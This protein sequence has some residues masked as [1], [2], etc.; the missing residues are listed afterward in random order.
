MNHGY[1]KQKATQ[2]ITSAKST[3]KNLKKSY[4]KRRERRAEEKREITLGQLGL[5]SY[6][7]P[8]IAREYYRLQEDNMKLEE[9]NHRLESRV[10][11]I[12][13]QHATYQVCPTVRGARF[14]GYLLPE[15]YQTENHEELGIAFAEYIENEVKHTTLPEGS[16]Y[17][18]AKNE[19][20]WTSLPEKLYWRRMRQYQ[21]MEEAK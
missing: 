1:A 9:A 12:E 18:Y 4:I 17:S 3:F 14:K 20:I 7:L 2:I 10:K 16:E 13:N 8:N 19:R 15:W 21:E 11:S 6:L 5:M